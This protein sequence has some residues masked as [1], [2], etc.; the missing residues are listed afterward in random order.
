MVYVKKDDKI[1][2]VIER[3]VS[4]KDLEFHITQLQAQ[5]ATLENKITE[6]KKCGIAAI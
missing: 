4:V 5:I 6:I 2:E 3:E 1:Y